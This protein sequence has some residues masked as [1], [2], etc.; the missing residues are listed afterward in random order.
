MS[1]HVGPAVD[2]VFAHGLARVER[3][4]ALASA[5]PARSSPVDEL[6]PGNDGAA[7][8]R[9]TAPRAQRGSMVQAPLLVSEPKS[10]QPMLSQLGSASDLGEVFDGFLCADRFRWLSFVGGVG[11]LRLRVFEL[12]QLLNQRTR[13]GSGTTGN[14]TSRACTARTRLCGPW[15][16]R[17]WRPLP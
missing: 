6:R 14:L 15:S 16:P 4:Q 2:R 8:T 12:D 10:S 13:R 17:A 11:R 5:R 3:G 9:R 1:K 7:P